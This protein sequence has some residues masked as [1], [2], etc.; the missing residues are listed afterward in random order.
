MTGN[1]IS[2]KICIARV[3]DRFNIDYSGFI[4]RV[5]NWIFSALGELD[6][7]QTWID[8]R[9]EGEVIDYMCLVPNRVKEIL[10]IEY[11]G[12]RLPNISQINASYAETMPSLLHNFEKYEIQGNYIITTFETG[13]IVFYVKVLPIE[14]DTTLKAYFPLIENNEDLLSSIDYYLIKRLLERGHNIPGFSLK[15]NNEFTNPGLAFEKSKR[16]VR[17]SLLNLR[18]DVRNEIS[19]QIRTF[20]SPTNYYNNVEFNSNQI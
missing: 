19:V 10:A 14:F 8:T 6:A 18:P 15:E 13:D 11:E 17:N 20:L 7:I 12:F 3:F 16:V 5:P 9:I 1:I 4:P 2:S